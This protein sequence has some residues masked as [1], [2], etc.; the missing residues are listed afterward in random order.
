MIFSGKPT[1]FWTTCGASTRTMA[2]FT[3][4]CRE[5][6][7]GGG[8]GKGRKAWFF[9]TQKPILKNTFLWFWHFWW[10]SPWDFVGISVL[11]LRSLLAVFFLKGFWQKSVRPS[12]CRKFV[13]MLSVE[14]LYLKTSLYLGV[15]LNDGTPKHPKMIIFSGKTHGCWVPPFSETSIFDQHWWIWKKCVIWII[16]SSP[17]TQETGPFEDSCVSISL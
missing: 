12:G 7:P 17:P 3:R 9:V 15:S 5:T 11:S 16:L 10:S 6:A 14:F 4:L 2:T 13:G 8:H 1:S